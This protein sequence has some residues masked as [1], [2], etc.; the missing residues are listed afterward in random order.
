MRALQHYTLFD[1]SLEI[2]RELIAEHE[3][4][5]IPEQPVVE[6]PTLLRYDHF[7]PDLVEALKLFPVVLLE[8]AYTKHPLEFARRTSGVAGGTYHVITSSGPRIRWI[9]P[10]TVIE[11]RRTV[12]PGS[13]GHLKSYRDPP[14]TEWRPASDELVA[15]FKNVL[16]TMKKHLVKVTV[17]PGDTIWVGTKTK[18][19]L[20]SG[21]LHIDR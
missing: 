8:G 21:D 1:E 9:L 7:A 5:A 10:G 15:A 17:S 3:L 16:R 14:G 12:T 18:K 19:E 2:L 13:I 4:V 6:K 20:D 11:P